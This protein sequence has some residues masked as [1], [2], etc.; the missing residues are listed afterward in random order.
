MHCAL[1]GIPGAI[2]Y[3]T[4]PLTY[5]MARWLV[6]VPY[7]GIANILLG[8]AMYPE[9]IQDRARAGALA[10]QLS[11][12]L[13]NPLRGSRTASQAAELRSMLARPAGDTESDWL[14]RNL[15]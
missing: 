1:A 8:E 12:C 14:L 10:D 6:R 13:D 2:A 11:E 9:F 15:A 3:R 4:D 5:L 7:R